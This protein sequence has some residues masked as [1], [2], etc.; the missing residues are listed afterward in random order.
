MN[1][2][3]ETHFTHAHHAIRDGIEFCYIIIKIKQRSF[4]SS[5]HIKLLMRK[6]MGHTAVSAT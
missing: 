6:G 5:E 2:F 3:F 1:K 4:K